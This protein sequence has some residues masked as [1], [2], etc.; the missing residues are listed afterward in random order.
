MGTVNPNDEPEQQ[1]ADIGPAVTDPAPDDEPEAAL[2]APEA[3]KGKG[4]K[5]DS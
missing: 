4:K 5:E 1:R 3:P 2:E